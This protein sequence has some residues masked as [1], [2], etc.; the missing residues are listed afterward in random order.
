MRR[1][2]PSS[3]FAL[4]RRKTSRPRHIR[5]QYGPGVVKGKGGDEQ[6]PGYREE[7]GVNPRSGQTFA[8]FRFMLDSLAGR[9]SPFY[10]RAAS[11]CR[12]A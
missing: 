12:N 8:A 1:S 5:G 11:G 7:E 4:S 3:L 10:V 9:E 2:R 6:V